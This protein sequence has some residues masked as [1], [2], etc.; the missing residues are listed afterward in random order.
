MFA[1]Y[2]I[3]LISLPKEEQVNQL[4]ILLISVSVLFIICGII[5]FLKLKFKDKIKNKFFQ[6]FLEKF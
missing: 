5:L 6:K 4:I 1:N 3:Y 2:W